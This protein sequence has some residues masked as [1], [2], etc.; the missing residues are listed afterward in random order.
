MYTPLPSGL[1]GEVQTR[2]I[3]IDRSLFYLVTGALVYLSENEP[4]EV[5]G[6][7]TVEAAKAALS[8][9]LDVYLEGEIVSAQFQVDGCELQVS[10]DSGETWSTLVDLS[11]CTVAGPAGPKGD[12]GDTGPTGA[13]GATGP[14]GPSG[15]KI[16]GTIIPYVTASVPSGCLA[17]DGA[18]YLRTDYQ[19]LYDV[20]HANYKPDADHFVVPDLRGRTMIGTGTGTGLTAR[21]MKDSVGTE[22]HVLTSGQMPVHTHTAKIGGTGGGTTFL[23][24]AQG[25]QA[26][27]ANT[28]INN[29]G[30]NEPHNNMQPSHAVGFCIVASV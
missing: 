1:A 2:P 9:M 11:T 6:T 18:T 17:C 14:T 5:T 27:T 8:A 24:G 20:L 23:D 10:Y 3:T 22:T 21:A 12:T 28:A 13:T 30:N 4:L 25:T 7:L 16:I 19:G 15:P 26:G 29:A